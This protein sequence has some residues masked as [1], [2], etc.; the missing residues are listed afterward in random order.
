MLHLEEAMAELRE[1]FRSTKTRSA[2]W[3]KTQLRGLER[4]LQEKERE[5]YKALDEDLGKHHT[6]AYRDEARKS[7]RYPHVT[8][9]IISV[10]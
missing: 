9:L 1:S 8:F 2:E 10:I 3:R 6:E 4:L 5:I 7:R